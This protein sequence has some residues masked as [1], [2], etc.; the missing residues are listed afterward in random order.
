MPPFLCLITLILANKSL[1]F[2]YIV[3]NWF[4][5]IQIVIKHWRDSSLQPQERGLQWLELCVGLND[6]PNIIS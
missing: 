3:T 6:S 1:L 2:S 5:F 4:F